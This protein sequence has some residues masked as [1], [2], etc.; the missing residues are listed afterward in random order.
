MTSVSRVPVRHSDSI[1][2]ATEVLAV[3]PIDGDCAIVTFRHVVSVSSAM[4]S[5]KRLA[6]YSSAAALH[7]I[8]RLSASEITH[9]PRISHTE[10]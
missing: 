8:P 3:E 4:S 2:A 7:R 9:L 1:G 6:K 5:A 10:R